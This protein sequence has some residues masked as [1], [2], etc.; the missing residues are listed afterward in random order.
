MEE[1]FE[2]ILNEF[3]TSEKKQT[4]VLLLGMSE[5]IKVSLPRTLWTAMK[6]QKTPYFRYRYLL[7]IPSRTTKDRGWKDT[8]FMTGDSHYQLLRTYLC[9]Y[10][11]KR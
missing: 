10:S 8:A 3:K 7:K 5:N 2:K 4:L 1:N 9:P 11:H 6:S